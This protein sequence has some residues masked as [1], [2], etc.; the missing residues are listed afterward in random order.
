MTTKVLIV[1]SGL[2]AT[3]GC[4][5]EPEDAEG[6][7]DVDVSDADPHADDEP[8]LREAQVAEGD[9]GPV[10]IDVAEAIDRSEGC[11]VGAS[12]GFS[13]VADENACT[14][15]SASS[16]ID[17]T[18]TWCGPCKRQAPILDKLAQSAEAAFRIVKVDIDESPGLAERYDANSVPTLMV[19]RG[20]QE[21]AQM[22]GL[23][24]RAE[25]LELL[26]VAR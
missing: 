23:S 21:I 16:I 7:D 14:S 9:S 13:N 17:L 24:D 19:F 6:R 26:A 2:L 22:S 8:D 11:F 5:I 4:V 1:V 10:D 12:S 20:G 25:L 18:A 15:A 3:V